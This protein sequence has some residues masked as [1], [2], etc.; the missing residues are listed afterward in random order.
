MSSLGPVV[1]AAQ[2]WMAGREPV[3]AE[4]AGWAVH[5]ALYHWRLFGL[6]EEIRPRWEGGRPTGPNVTGLNAA[7][8]SAAIAFLRARA[9]APAHRSSVLL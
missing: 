8:R 7:G 1:V 5:R 6:L 9:T 2:G 4:R 3:T